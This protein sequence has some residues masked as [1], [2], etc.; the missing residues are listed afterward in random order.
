MS[1]FRFATLATAAVV[2][3]AC[4]LPNPY[5]SQPAPVRPV[6]PAPVPPP[7]TP[8]PTPPVIELPEAPVAPLPEASN[9][10]L[11]RLADSLAARL[12]ASPAL[13]E[14]NGPVLLDDI[15]NQAGS[16][17]DTRGLTERLQAA[18]AGSLNFVGGAQVSSLRQQL[19]YQG[20]RA[21]MAS[22]VRLGKQSGAAYLLSGNLSRGGAGFSLSGQ[23]MELAS[24]E[25][26]WSDSVSGR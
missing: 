24:G 19:A 18:L 25:V 4:S 6:T 26:L 5:S 7:A 20:G 13:A 3:S 10:N 11:E 8:A 23:L 14:V 15:R 9:A 17:V 16:P 2:L 12:R 21:D 1:L 22:L